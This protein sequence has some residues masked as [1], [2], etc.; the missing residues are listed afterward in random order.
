MTTKGALTVTS[1]ATAML[2]G[3]GIFL[4]L[5]FGSIAKQLAQDYASRT[6]GVQ[7]TIGR[8][9]VSFQDRTVQISHLR[10]GNPSGYKN[11]HAAVVQSIAIQAGELGSELLEFKDVAVTSADI[12]LEVTP[13][14]TNLT[15]IRRNLNPQVGA[16]Q[17][18]GEKALKVILDQLVMSGTIHPSISF[19]EREIPPFELPPITL[20]GIGRNGQADGQGGVLVG[21][22]IAQ[23]WQAVSKEAIVASNRQG[24]LDGLPVQVLHDAGLGDIQILKEQIGKDLNRVQDSIRKMFE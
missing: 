20:R 1:L 6:L 12:F 11:P 23:I 7:V 24:Y 14:G 5:N 21:E 10:I 19:V 3:G 9:D 17:T 2:F 8:L 22:A 4:Y 18:E 15:D 16:A 13:E